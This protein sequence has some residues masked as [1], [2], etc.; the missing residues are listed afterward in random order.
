M[1]TDDYFWLPS[2]PP[3]QHKRPEEKRLP[4]LQ[5]DADPDGRWVL[6]GSLCGWGDP[7]IPRFDMVILLSAPTP[8]RLERLHHRE[9]KRFGAAA[10]AEQGSHHA[11]FAKFIAWAA[12]Y[13]DGDMDDRSRVRHDR[14][15]E[16]LPCP[17]LRLDGSLPPSELL[18]LALV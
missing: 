15:L 14:W 12:S 17:A 16:A 6:S 5:A 18:A 11:G 9:T 8:L 1:D 3:C 13:D 10:I 2:D 7:L 4:L